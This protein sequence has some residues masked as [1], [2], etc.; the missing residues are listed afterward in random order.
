MGLFDDVVLFGKYDG[1]V[2]EVFY[3]GV[4]DDE[5]VDV[6]VVGGENVGNVG[7]D[8]GFVLD[9]VVEDMVFWRGDGGGGGF[10]ED[11]GYGC[12]G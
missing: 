12:L 10:V 7:E 5:G 11:V 8:V 4:V 2:G 3:F 6:E 1:Y 9:E